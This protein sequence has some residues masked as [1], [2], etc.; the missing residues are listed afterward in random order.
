MAPPLQSINLSSLPAAIATPMTG[1]AQATVTQPT[2]VSCATDPSLLSIQR[3]V[4]EEAS[5]QRELLSLSI[6]ECRRVTSLFLAGTRDS[7]LQVLMEGF[8]RARMLGFSANPPAGAP[9]D[10]RS[11]YMDLARAI[12]AARETY[13]S[14][15]FAVTELQTKVR[16]L[17]IYVNI[18]PQLEYDPNATTPALVPRDHFKDI[19]AETRDFIR[20]YIHSPIMDFPAFRRAVARVT[21][22]QSDHAKSIRESKYRAV[23]DSIMNNSIEQIP[24]RVPEEGEETP[25]LRT[26]ILTNDPAFQ[27]FWATF[28][29]DHDHALG[30][31][32][33]R[34]IVSSAITDV[35]NALRAIENII[36]EFNSICSDQSIPQPPLS[37]L[38]KKVFAYVVLDITRSDF[39]KNHPRQPDV[40]AAIRGYEAALEA[41]MHRLADRMPDEALIEVTPEVQRRFET[42]HPSYRRTVQPVVVSTA[43]GPDLPPAQTISAPALHSAPPA[44]VPVARAPAPTPTVVP[45][46]PVPAAPQNPPPTPATATVIRPEDIVRYGNLYISEYPNTSTGSRETYLLE[47]ADYLLQSAILTTRSQQGSNSAQATGQSPGAVLEAQSYS[48]AARNHVKNKLNIVARLCFFIGLSRSPQVRACFMWLARVFS[49]RTLNKD[50]KAA[51][52]A[53]EASESVRL[54]STTQLTKTIKQATRLAFLA[55]FHLDQNVATSSAMS[56]SDGVIRQ[57]SAPERIY[58][59]FL[60]STSAVR[61]H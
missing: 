26:T 61:R 60:R 42:L 41:V 19:L 22:L 53:F 39:I 5:Q 45:V 49:N 23:R 16:D 36:R 30:N 50:I 38:V 52:T 59:D 12:C 14:L 51:Q 8:D 37:E 20:E 18:P 56:F 27:R 57:A 7:N 47:T 54:F 46:T 35:P 33:V 31:E 11:A 34:A 9:P 40:A 28:M 21:K 25:P 2:A 15:K 55:L 43:A 4:S 24:L 29:E 17:E 58:T 6:A 44:A 32:T 1:A 13:L 10:L 48:T 3:R